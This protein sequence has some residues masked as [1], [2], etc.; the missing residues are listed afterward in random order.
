M[1]AS[2][3]SVSGKPPLKIR[4]WAAGQVSNPNW[5]Q[6]CFLCFDE[7]LLFCGALKFIFLSLNCI[8]YF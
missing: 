5:K 4:P 8:N 2:F 3:Q 7:V 1:A 6:I